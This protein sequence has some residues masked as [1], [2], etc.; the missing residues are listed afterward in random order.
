MTVMD[1]TVYRGDWNDDGHISELF[2]LLERPAWM[3]RAACRGMDPNAFFPERGE[4]T[5]PV[6]AVCAGCPVQAECLVYAETVVDNTRPTGIYGG[7]SGRE[8]RRRREQ[9][10]LAA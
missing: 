1:G 7:M 3:A 9:R 2:A 8:R 4:P 5:G 10:R 6:K